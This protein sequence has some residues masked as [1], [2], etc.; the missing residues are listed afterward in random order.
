MTI[1]FPHRPHQN[2]A[3]K[4]TYL[5]CFDKGHRIPHNSAAKTLL[6]S[7]SMPTN[8]TTP[9]LTV[10]EGGGTDL[11]RKK[12]LLFNQPWALDLDEFDRLARLCGLSRAEEFDL[13]L[14]RVRHRARGNIEAKYL[15][16]VL[17]GRKSEAECLGR[18]LERRNGLGLR[19][20][21]S[22]AA[23]RIE[24]NDEDNPSAQPCP[25]DD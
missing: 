10:I 8:E 16:A 23:S 21:G 6:A 14:E 12:W 15:L 22:D 7:R 18:I 3:K 20:I 9:A 13:M 24:G 19:V 17:E 1:N 4:R 2:V 25:P 5:H 11:A